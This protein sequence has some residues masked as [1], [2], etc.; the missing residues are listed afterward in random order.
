[1]KIHCL[2]ELKISLLVLLIAGASPVA[3]AAQA[4][5]SIINFAF[6]PNT[7]AI[8]VNDSVVWTWNS[9]GIS[10]STTNTMGLWFSGTHTAPFSFTNR[11]T[12]VGSFPYYCTVHPTTM[13]N[14]FVNVSAVTPVAV[15]LT[16]PQK[17]SQ[18]QFRFTYSANTGLTYIIQR[19]ANLFA[20]T[21]LATN[22]A[23]SSSVNFT[24]NAALPGLNFYRVGRVVGP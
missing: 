10:H 20:L 18:T 23:T 7:V 8:N 14:N 2:S 4:N 21:N 6:S 3:H 22:V 24:D 5:V 11:F 17:L 13:T 1:M 16:N 19:S 15:V 9:D 12:S